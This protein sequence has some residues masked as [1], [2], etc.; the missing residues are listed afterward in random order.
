M[1][2][3]K[4]RNDEQI[5][6]LK[7][8]EARIIKETQDNLKLHNEEIEKLTKR[9]DDMSSKFAQMLQDTLTKMQAKIDQAN[10]NWKEENEQKRN[11]ENIADIGSS[12]I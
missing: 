7:E 8:E 11:Y 5:K 4:V 2:S 9:I 12:N 1:L 3:T 6:E 10:E